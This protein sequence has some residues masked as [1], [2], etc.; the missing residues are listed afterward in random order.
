MKNKIYVLGDSF[1]THSSLS[2]GGLGYFWVNEFHKQFE[3]THDLILDSMPSRD[4]QTIIDN[5]IKLIKHI[6][7]EDILIVCI[8]FFLR[9]RV[10]LHPK[11]F[12]V[13]RYDEFSIINRF[14]THHSWYTSDLE[15]IYIGDEIIE[16]DRL[17]EYII[18]LEQLF[19]NS[20]AVEKNY[21]EVIKSI[22]DLTDCG[23]YIFSWDDM[24]NTIEEIE[25]KNQLDSKLGWSTL[26]DLYKKTN[27]NEGKLGDLHWDYKFQEKFVGYL[28]EKFKK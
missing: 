7:K 18:F 10:P 4:V 8:P 22:Y 25:Y 5:W 1:C 3:D 21:N 6:K 27:G 12:M 11:D 23:K 13:D 17:D 16:K 14:V 19:F 26:D 24:K 20:D 9:I 15:K 28:L 2:S